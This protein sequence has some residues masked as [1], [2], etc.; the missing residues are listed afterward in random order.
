VTRRL[1]ARLRLPVL[2]LAGLLLT[3]GVA[4]AEHP[5]NSQPPD[6]TGPNPPAVGNVLTGNNGS[7]IYANGSSCGSDCTY[8]F[9]FLRCKANTAENCVVVK[10]DSDTRTYTVQSADVGL[11][12]VLKVT[13]R[14][15]DC[16]AHGVDCR[17]ISREAFS[18]PMLPVGGTAATPPTVVAIAPSELPSGV[19]GSGY[20][21][22]L[23]A[24]GG[25]GPYAFSLISGSLPP[26]LSLASGGTISGTPTQAGTY[27]FTVRVTGGGGVAGTRAFSL[28]VALALGPESLADGVTGVA[29]SQQLSVATGGTQPIAFRLAEGTLP[30]G[31]GFTGSGVLSGT[32]TKAGTFPFVVEATDARGATGRAGYTVRIGHPSLTVG[33]E[34]RPAFSD[35]PYRQRLTVS[36]GTAPY[37]WLP[38]EGAVLPPGLTLG[39]D[40]VLR[41]TPSAPAG[42]FAFDVTVTDNF[43]APGR[44][45]VTLELRGATV[46]IRPTGLVPARVGQ[47]YSALLRAAGGKAPYRF[48]RASGRLPA[49]LRLTQNGRLV[50]TPRVAG[51]FRFVVRAADANGA[52]KTRVYVLRVT[53]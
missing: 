36:G 53:R 3:A 14:K 49:G 31:L 39:R 16:N 4:S 8:T 13:A 37:R 18:S 22:A 34:V 51:A 30:D 1:S 45:T 38:A 35:R 28:R 2:V 40:G 5:Q 21:Q 33:T 43:G 12:I 48:S 20:S 27:A 29:Y 6:I 19:A 9:E 32:P 41:G 46:L 24:S 7:W 17:D 23:T 47:A 44:A 26:G 42:T 11:S 25:S 52:A 50:G 15:R 10:P